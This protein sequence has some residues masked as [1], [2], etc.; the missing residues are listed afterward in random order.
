VTT[1]SSRIAVELT[2]PGQ[3]L[4]CLGFMEAAEVLCGGAE[5]H[6]GKHGEPCF[7]LSARS[8]DDPVVQVID[9][10][11]TAALR[12]VEPAVMLVDDDEGA[13]DNEAGDHESADDEAK[14]GMGTAL[15]DRGHLFPNGR[16]EPTA[17]PVRFVRDGVSLEVSHWAD[18]SSRETFKLYSG[19]RSAFGIARAM[20]QGTR[21]K[22]KKNQAQGD[23]LTEGLVQLWQRERVARDPFSVLT[24]LQGTFNFDPRKGWSGLDAGY[25]PDKQGHGV[26]SSPLVELL[27]PIGLEHVRPAPCGNGAYRYHIWD[28]PLTAVLARVAFQGALPGVSSRVF[29]FTFNQSGKNKNLT[30]ATEERG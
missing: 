11:V 6:F 3:V 2:N 24:P 28:T 29:R 1:T 17:F 7:I 12:V 9:F 15:P 25:S 30:H 21:Q 23:L 10:L 27:A 22:P 16:P 14:P 26:E 18:G 20:Q 5:A 13:D 19:N 4:A 8:S